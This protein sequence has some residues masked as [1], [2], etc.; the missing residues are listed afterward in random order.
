MVAVV[1]NAED[2]FAE[3]ECHRPRVVVLHLRSMVTV[4][5][6]LGCGDRRALLDRAAR[7]VPSAQVVVIDGEESDDE[8]VD[9]SL[10]NRVGFLDVSGGLEDLLGALHLLREGKSFGRRNS[11]SHRARPATPTVIERLSA[12]LTVREQE[13]LSLLVDGAPTDRIVIEL[14]ISVMTVRSHIQSIFYKLGVHS[15]LEAA[16]LAVRHGL[17]AT[18]ESAGRR[19]G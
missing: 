17:V 10:N 3:I 16:A 15:R 13:C 1:G 11:D 12:S 18:H 4:T 5:G 14:G 2:L 7:L 9:I 8:P 19:T 6:R